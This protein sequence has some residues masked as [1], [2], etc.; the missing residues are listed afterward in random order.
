MQR[1]TVALG[2]RERGQTAQVWR[3]GSGSPVVLLH[4]AW[5]GA[6]AHWAPVWE[7]LAER[8]T[9]IAPELPGFFPGSGEL[10]S[11][12]A[13]IADWVAEV[14]DVAQCGPAA[15]VGNSFGAC[16]AWHVALQHAERCRA[17]VLVDGGPPAPLP[18]WLRWALSSTPLQGLAAA[19][20]LKRV[21]G[22]SA[23]ST[24]FSDPSRAPPEVQRAL[25]SPDPAL[26]KQLLR[27]FLRSGV[28]AGTPP[29]PTTIVWGADDRLPQSDVTA[30]RALQAR[31]HGARLEVIEKAGHL[32][33]AEQPE[34]FAELLL[35]VIEHD[36]PSRAT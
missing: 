19:Q 10:K 33:Q 35:R 12:Y 1:H 32:P 14:I 17:L 16:I 21:F 2:H 15:V 22:P 28:P 6:R 20:L 26:V 3:G 31:L 8:H 34:R 23:L 5:A 7:R 29:Q 27:M 4:G 36:Q 25:Q 24:G 9:V 18:G 13:D 11:T 30:A